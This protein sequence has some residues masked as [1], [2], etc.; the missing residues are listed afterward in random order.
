M[1]QHSLPPT[2]SCLHLDLKP[3]M[4]TKHVV[5][6]A[7]APKVPTNVLNHAIISNGMVYCSGQLPINPAT[8]KLV[9]GDI[10]AHTVR[11]PTR[12]DGR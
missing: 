11:E 4:S 2:S 1:L 12:I 8:G 6:A 3:T 7:K 5:N 10:I 9:D